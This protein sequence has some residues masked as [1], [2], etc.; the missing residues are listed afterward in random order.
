MKVYNSATL[1]E[2]RKANAGK[3]MTALAFK[4]DRF[5][6][7]HGGANLATRFVV[8]N[9]LDELQALRNRITN[10]AQA[11]SAADIEAFF[12]KFYIEL[13]RRVAES[14][15]LTTMIAREQ[16][17]LDFPEVVTLKELLPYRGFMG[18]VQGTNDPV[19]LI[20]QNTGVTDTVTLYIK[21]LGWKDSLKNL[22]YNKFFTMDRVIQAAA[23][24][25]MDERNKEVIGTPIIGATFVA[26]QKVDADA[27]SGQ[28]L[29]EHTYNTILAAV[30]KLRGLKDIFTGQKIVAPSINILHNS[31]DGWQIENVIRGQLN[32][33]G[34]SARA[35][36]RP[37]LPINALIEYDQ[38][39]NHLQV[40]GKVTGSYPGVTAGKC[41][42]YVPDIMLV[43]KKRPL[44]M[45]SGIGSV[46]ELSTEERAWY[47][48]QGVYTKQFLGSSFAGTT[49]GAGYGY[50]IEVTLP[51]S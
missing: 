21:A 28:T 16:T 45:E 31:A 32:G 1:S 35:S 46:L 10:S 43:A 37:A 33:N 39:I 26:S 11:P 8:K 12:G 42:V 20:E 23:D 50:I 38:G 18:M 47:G 49:V 24:A 25:Y 17:D 27:T 36:N 51:T 2:E 29:D 44:T 22:L 30:K 48:V 40:V 6:N 5:A 19:P 15:D 7:L 4:G 3:I 14:V 34:S 9:E 41:Y 13:A